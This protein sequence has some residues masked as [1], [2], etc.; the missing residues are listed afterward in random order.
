MPHIV[1]DNCRLCLFTECVEHCPV[2]CFHADAERIYIDPEVCI[3]CG[4]CVPVCPVQAIHD[5]IDM[6]DEHHVWI[7]VNA[8]HARDLPVVQAKREPL[9]T[10]VARRAE[11]GF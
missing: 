10:A 2:Q 4:A 5:V 9:P 3:D 6:A 11:L 7:L 1:T 8:E